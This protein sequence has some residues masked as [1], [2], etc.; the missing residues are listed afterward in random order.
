M[1]DAAGSLG[2]TRD[3][4]LQEPPRLRWG[5]WQARPALG[6]GKEAGP[7]EGLAGEN[8]EGEP[9]S[10]SRLVAFAALPLSSGI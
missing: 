3:P 9:G 1:A 5:S 7:R 4:A 8:G 10:P 6:S 2:R